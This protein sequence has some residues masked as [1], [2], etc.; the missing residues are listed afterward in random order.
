MLEIER[1]ARKEVDKMGERINSTA[2]P[3]IK[4]RHEASTFQ[5]STGF[6]KVEIKGYKKT[7]KKIEKLAKEARQL[8]EE[9]EKAVELKE[10]LFSINGLRR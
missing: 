1:G 3:P 8:N 9:L 2:R 5:E 7:L 4:D 10:R 6:V